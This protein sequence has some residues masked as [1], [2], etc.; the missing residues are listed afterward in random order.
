M[1][2]EVEAEAFALVALTKRIEDLEKG[3]LQF[4][5]MIGQILTAPEKLESIC[6]SFQ[7]FCEIVASKNKGWFK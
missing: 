5:T 1:M 3:Q 2:N 7:T 6:R 4:L